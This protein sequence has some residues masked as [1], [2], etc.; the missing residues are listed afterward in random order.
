METFTCDCTVCDGK[1]IQA[2]VGYIAGTPKQVR[3]MTHN[4]VLGAHASAGIGRV[5]ADRAGIV[6]VPA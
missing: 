5:M 1:S 4:Y 2:P 3:D 6:V